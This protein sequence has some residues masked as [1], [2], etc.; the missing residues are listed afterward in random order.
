MDQLFRMPVQDMFEIGDEGLA[1]SGMIVTGRVTEGSA[2]VGDMLMIVSESGA[3]RVAQLTG[4]ELP[5]QVTDTALC[6]DDVGL[7]FSGLKTADV[8]KGDVIVSQ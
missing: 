5:G 4:V 8:S 2:T 6:G 3:K 1:V 7:L